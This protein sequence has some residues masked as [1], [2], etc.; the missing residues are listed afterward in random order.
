MSPTT[1]FQ[2]YTGA[3]S[4]TAD[5]TLTT[6]NSAITV[7]GTGDDRRKRKR[8]H[9]GHGTGNGTVSGDATGI[10]LLELVNTGTINFQG[11]LAVHSLGVAIRGNT[12]AT[13]TVTGGGAVTVGDGSADDDFIVDGTRGSTSSSNNAIGTVNFSGAGSFAAV[14]DDFHVGVKGDT[15]NGRSSGIVTLSDDANITADEVVV[16]RAGANGAAGSNELHLGA[17]TTTIATGTLIVGQQKSGGLIDI[18]VGGDVTIGSSGARTSILIGNKNEGTGINPT[19]TVDFTG[20]SQVEIFAS[21]LT[22]S[23]R[24]QSSAGNITGNLIIDGTNSLI[25]ANTITVGLRDNGADGIATGTIQIL[26]QTS[27]TVNAGDIWIGRITGG[28][29]DDPVAA[30]SPGARRWST[31]TRSRWAAPPGASTRT[32]GRALFK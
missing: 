7:D 9:A 19:A 24:S 31:R 29:G 13:L 12:N 6:T 26:G 2:T 22:V 23:Q 4:L 11:D 18:A 28:S 8:P 25:D 3:V 30:P 20:A 17:G 1:G 21:T 5:V 27:T 10:D 15:L 16:G 32:P 14:V